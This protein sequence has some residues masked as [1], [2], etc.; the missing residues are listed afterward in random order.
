MGRA[1]LKRPRKVARRFTWK[2]RKPP[3]QRVRLD[4]RV[5]N[6]TLVRTGRKVLIPEPFCFSGIPFLLAEFRTRPTPLWSI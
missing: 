4:I 1:D 3:L 6:V 5:S 2:R